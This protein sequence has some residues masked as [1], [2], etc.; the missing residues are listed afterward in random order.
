MD[1]RTFCALAGA[2][3]VQARTAWSTEGF[4]ARPVKLVAPYPPGGT[5]DI[6]ARAIAQQM[7]QRLG[8]S[9]F[10]DNRGG[11]NGTLGASSVA[12]SAPDGYTAL[13]GAVHQAIAQ[14]LYPR[15]TY[16]IQKDLT[17][18][19]F[20]G[21]VNHVLL[22]NNALPVRTVADLVAY[23]K[24]NP[25]KLNYA[26]PG[27]GSLHHLM[28]EQFKTATGTSMSHV[29]YKGAGQAMVDLISGSVHVY[30]ETMPSALQHV[31]AGSVR[32]LAVTA[33]TRS[34]AMPE[35]PTIAERGIENYDASSW[36]GL[37]VPARTPQPIV[38]RLNQAVNDSFAS[39][40]FADQWK[41]LGAEVGGGSPESLA[42]LLAE[43]STRWASVAKASGIRID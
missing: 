29:P 13:F 16:D 42:Q 43:E 19:G 20:L 11:A 32:A 12:H 15:L 37:F 2:S 1:R 31:R 21:R 24:A 28:A 4:P 38:V 3:M 9:M 6:L 8:Q 5:V 34:A 33:R 41:G 40:A 14:S 18:V 10:V 36:Y 22:C 39:S 27:N 35:V 23:L 26:T 7:G 25:G 30:F 17:P